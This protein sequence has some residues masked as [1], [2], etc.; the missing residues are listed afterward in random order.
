M[1]QKRKEARPESKVGFKDEADIEVFE[2]MRAQLQDLKAQFQVLSKGKPNEAI[3]AFKLRMVNQ[4]LGR[5]NNYL[6]L[7][8]RPFA[9]FT[10]FSEDDLPSNSDVLIMLTQYG[11]CLHRF[12]VGNSARRQAEQGLFWIVN[13]EVTERRSSW[14]LL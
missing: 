6:E 11:T 3:N 4:L 8:A 2:K 12:L 5:A 7:E 13:G 9:D 14:E 1:A 10:E